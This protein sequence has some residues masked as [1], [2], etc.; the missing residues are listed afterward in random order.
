M[1]QFRSL[2]LVVLGCW[3]A[4]CSDDAG[5]RSGARVDAGD[6]GRAASVVLVDGAVVP[7]TDQTQDGPAGGDDADPGELGSS[8]TAGESGDGGQGSVA[9]PASNDEASAT[10][11]SAVVPSGSV[12]TTPAIP[13]QDAGSGVTQPNDDTPPSLGVDAATPE[14]PVIEPIPQP[15][16][17]AEAGALFAR[18]GIARFELA[19]DQ[20]GMDALLLDPYTYVQGDIDITLADGTAIS[21]PDAGIRLKG[22]AGSFR[23]LGLKSS[24]LIKTNEYVQ[25]QELLGLKKFALN[26]MVQ[27]A[28]MIHEQIAYDLFRAMN[29][30]APRTSYARVLLNGDVL[31]LYASIEVVDNKDFLE[32]WFG[33]DEGNLY[34]GVYGSDFDAAN[35]GSFDQDR[36]DDIGLADLQQLS[37]ALAAMTDPSTLLSD[38]GTVIDVERFIDFVA[39]ELYM[40][41]WDGYA[42]SSNNY[43]VYRAPGGLWT[44]M[45][46]GTD[47][48]FEDDGTGI[49]GQTAVVQALCEASTPCRQR[50]AEAIER[51]I[52]QVDALD[53]AGRCDELQAL[54]SD[55]VAEDPLKEYSNEDVVSWIDRTRSFVQNRPQRIVP[56]LR[57]VDPADVDDDGD[58]ASG[59]GVDCNDGD[60]LI[61]PGAAEACNTVDDNCDG[62]RDED[63]MCP[64]CVEL[65]VEGQPRYAYCFSMRS[66][67]LAQQS[68]AERGGGLVTV[69]DQAQAD[70]LLQGAAFIGGDWWIGLSDA[71]EEGSF[72]WVDQSPVDY[73]YWGENEPNNAGE[74]EHCAEMRSDGHWNDVH[75]D[76]EL[77]Y[78]CELP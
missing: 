36:G 8:T 46:W 44:F 4:S 51:V 62:Q 61:F 39:T 75:C 3:Q 31:G 16:P 15:V 43:Y 71:A 12:T 48:T 38:L 33:S 26:S 50:L 65:Q 41:H 66:W 29:V 20:A 56:E 55:A 34:E 19:L 52:G 45:P 30:P 67:S 10:D 49:W 17:G 70:A 5:A 22:R 11:D 13:G 78:I 54:I 23:E 27:D 24:F 37:D 69:R 77:N 47:Q 74:A 58:G 7:L 53:F 25:G 59:C 76:T 6:A 1:K 64:E 57:C 14:L 63:P 68:C 72:V 42:M 32:R 28:S 40:A 21:L 9:D 60:P 18:G 35:L 2:G 73:L